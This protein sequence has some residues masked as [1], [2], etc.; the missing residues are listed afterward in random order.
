M[1]NL[2]LLL[3]DQTP[4]KKIPDFYVD[5]HDLGVSQR[6][7]DAMLS[8]INQ[9]FKSTPSLYSKEAS[10]KNRLSKHYIRSIVQDSSKEHTQ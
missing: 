6:T 10:F 7:A 9:I 8:D 5:S 4:L 2:D 3:E 1:S